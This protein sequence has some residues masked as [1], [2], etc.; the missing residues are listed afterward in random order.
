M[1]QQ[2]VWTVNKEGQPVNKEV[3]TAHNNVQTVHKEVWIKEKMYHAG[4]K[5]DA[6]IYNEGYQK[7]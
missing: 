6:V 1:L 7:Y 5:I 4:C 2:N 3:Q